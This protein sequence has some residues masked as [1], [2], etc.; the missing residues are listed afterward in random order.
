MNEHTRTNAHISTNAQGHRGRRGW[1]TPEIDGTWLEGL[2]TGAALSLTLRTRRVDMVLPYCLVCGLD[3]APSFTTGPPF[4]AEVPPHLADKVRWQ[5]TP[6]GAVVSDIMQ[7][8]SK[9]RRIDGNI[10]MRALTF[11]PDLPLRPS[12]AGTSLLTGW[13]FVRSDS[14]VDG[15]VLLH[16][17]PNHTA[18]DLT[19]VTGAPGKWSLTARFQPD[20]LSALLSNMS[21]VVLRA[22]PVPTDGVVVVPPY[23]VLR[24]D[25]MAP[26]EESQLAL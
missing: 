5:L 3:N 16:V 20:G 2:Y 26:G 10:T 14:S 21:S 18:L 1:A 6:K 19:A 22:L 4:G 17:G 15:A 23:S 12:L 7:A 8:V 9:R 11:S 25:R 13:A 24:L